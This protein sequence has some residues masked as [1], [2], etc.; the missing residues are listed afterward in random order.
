M[1]L[2]EKELPY[3]LWLSKT[4]G[5]GDVAIRKLLAYY[6]SP[7]KI[8]Y[9]DDFELD[10]LADVGV[11]TPKLL[12]NL[13]EAKK[14]S[15]IYT[16][17]KAMTDKGIRIIPFSSPEYP[18]KL[19]NIPGAP[20]YLFVIGRLPLKDEP[21]IAIVGTREVSGYGRKAAEYFGNELASK[22]VSVISGMARGVD[23][24][25]QRAALKSGGLSYGVLGCGVDVCYP[26]QNV[27]IYEKMK[28]QGGLISPFVPGTEPI[29]SLFPSR[30][31]IISGLSDAVLVVEARMKSGSKITVDFALEQGIDVFAVPGRITDPL[32]LGTNDLIKQGAGIADCAD[33]VLEYVYSKKSPVAEKP[34]EKRMNIL[35]S[36]K[37]RLTSEQYSVLSVLEET[38]IGLEDIYKEARKQNPNISFKGL[39]SLL[40]GLCI[41]G[42]AIDEAGGF[43]LNF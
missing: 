27:D 12:N 6:D 40:T 23:G 21:I 10:A 22:G 18:E 29:P 3:H 11:L 14:N 15:D 17:Y 42:Y 31:R 25:S 39:R 34:W 4:K 13:K 1:E 35:S 9:S 38:P 8:F 16:P 37:N 7:S 43:C 36:L 30:N 2:N 41:D 5:F 24:I 26:L 32:S 28:E 33:T 19:R 20:T